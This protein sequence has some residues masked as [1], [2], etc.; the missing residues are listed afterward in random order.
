MD[1]EVKGAQCLLVTGCDGEEELMVTGL[2]TVN[3]L[4]EEIKEFEKI[5]YY[6]IYKLEKLNEVF[7]GAN[8]V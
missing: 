8:I 7:I 1:E 5:D 4:I 3:N 2:D 6:C